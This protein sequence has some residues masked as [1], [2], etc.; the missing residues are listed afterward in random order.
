M[1]LALV[2]RLRPRRRPRA[3][4]VLAWTLL[5]LVAYAGAR[6]A[7]MYRDVAVDD[8]FITFR[9]SLNLS[10]G[11]GPVYN[12]G[13]R[14]EGTSAM[15]FAVLLTPPVALGVDPLAAAKVVGVTAF[16][17]TAVLAFATVRAL[18]PHGGRVLGL[19]AAAVVAATTPLAYFAESGLETT[20]YVALL[21][22]ALFLLVHPDRSP[23]R[24]HWALAMAAVAMTRPEGVFFFLLLLALDATR[25]ALASPRRAAKNAAVAAGW[26]SAAYLPFLLFRVAYYG[27]LVPN[28]VTAKSGAS[29]RLLEA[30]G[31]SS[32]VEVLST[33]AGATTLK[34]YLPRLGLGAFLVLG[35]LSRRRTAFATTVCLAIAASCLLLVTWN[36]GDWVGYDRLF[37][38]AM[39]PMAIALALGLG[40]VVYRTRPRGWP[41]ALDAA[42][43]ALVVAWSAASASDYERAFTCS[44]KAAMEY[45]LRLSRSLRAARL[46]S[47]VL[48]TDMAGGIPYYTDLRTVDVF[49]LCDKTIAHGGVPFG[50]MGKTDMA[51]VARK[52]PT[53]YVFNF[54]YWIADLYRNPAFADQVNDYWA[55]LTPE[56]VRRNHQDWKLLLVRRDRPG[57][58]ALVAQL[59]AKLVDPRDELRRLHQW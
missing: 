8:A 37:V 4:D 56:Y 18:S 14:V 39:A 49:G 29:H 13:E 28:T 50:T 46:D 15:L 24:P 35:G 55:V 12:V 54:T 59:D 47:D 23:S 31:L 3:A 9:Y 41:A 22:L 33:G 19:V 43:I 34:G 53:F 30:H 27:A 32:L 26:F 6:H 11:H 20:T 40:A 21:T 44:Y 58:S 36:D 5:A 45:S 10:R 57:L 48:A 51:Y 7:W 42:L 17:A 1:L 52:R 2:R 38:P 25:L 16:V